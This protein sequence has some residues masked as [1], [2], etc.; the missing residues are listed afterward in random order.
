MSS[1]DWVSKVLSGARVCGGMLLL[2][3]LLAACATTGEL[4]YITADG[5]RKTACKT[6]YT[7]APKVDKYAVQYVLSYCARQ[8]V[9]QGH[10]LV[11]PS[12]LELD[13]SIP[14]PPNGQS[15]SFEYATKLFKRGQL[16]DR[17]YGYIVAYIDLG[18]GNSP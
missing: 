2:A 8:A 11:D 5:D 16:S 14:A 9:R 17:E 18:L 7:W 3:G 15:W 13:L 6:E 1:N 10:T 4:E 12:L